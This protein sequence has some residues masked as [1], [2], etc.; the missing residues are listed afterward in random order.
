MRER[1]SVPVVPRAT[2]PQ[3]PTSAKENDDAAKRVGNF[4]VLRKSECFQ[5]SFTEYSGLHTAP[6]STHDQAAS[7]LIRL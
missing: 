3:R 6:I 4:L 7:K 5:L 2:Y 1:Q